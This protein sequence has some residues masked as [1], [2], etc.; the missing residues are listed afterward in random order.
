MSSSERL[1]TIASVSGDLDD[2][3]VTERVKNTSFAVAD[4]LSFLDGRVLATVGV[5]YQEIETRSYAYA[6]GAFTSGYSSDATTPAF[7][8]IASIAVNA[9]C[10][11]GIAV[12][13]RPVRAA[14]A[15]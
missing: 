9:A 7:A 11:R 12:R 3:N 13:K 14:A 6:D 15:A 1:E 10:T 4:V 8:S 5:R 2:P